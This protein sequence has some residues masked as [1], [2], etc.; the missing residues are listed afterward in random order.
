MRTRR[1]TAG[2]PRSRPR[3]LFD[4]A[5]GRQVVLQLT[6][7]HLAVLL[8]TGQYELVKKPRRKTTIIEPDELV[9]K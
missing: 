7:E 1:A 3:R 4:K 6:D 5:T 2:A 9:E 8:G